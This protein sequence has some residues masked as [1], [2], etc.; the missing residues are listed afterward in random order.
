MNT[1]ELKLSLIQKIIQIE[2]VGSLQKIQVFLNN[3]GSLQNENLKNTSSLRNNKD[4]EFNETEDFT[5]YIKEW[6]KNM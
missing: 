5:D 1:R 6:V 3:S 4:D 2:D